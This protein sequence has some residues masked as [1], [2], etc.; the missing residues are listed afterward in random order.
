VG[1][2]LALEPTGFAPAQVYQKALYDAG[3]PHAAFLT[4]GIEAEYQRLKARGVVFRSGPTP[5][6][7]IIGAIFEDGCGNLVNLVQP[8]QQGNPS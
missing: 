4:D 8:V 2:Q 5:M 7:P 6:G 3:I 1:V